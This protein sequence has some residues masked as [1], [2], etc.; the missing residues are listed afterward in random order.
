MTSIAVLGPGGVGGFIAGALTRAGEEVTVLARESSAQVLARDGL[1]I[2]SVILGEFDARP[3]AV[4]QL[5]EPVD[6]LIIATKAVDLDA[7]LQRVQ[8]TPGLVVP[9][10]NGLDHMQLLRRR[11][12]AERVAAGTIRIEADRPEPGR[13]VH[14][15]R[16]LQVDLASEHAEAAPALERLAGRLNRA[17]VPARIGPSEAQILWSKLV[18]LNALALTTSASAERLG[19]IRSD[20]VWREALLG[21]LREGAAVARADGAELDPAKPLGE[22]EAAHAELNSSMQRDVAAGREP[23]LD[24]IAGSVLRAARRHGLACPTIERLSGEVARRA[25]IEPPRV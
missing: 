19:F 13:I 21:C 1:H 18:R 25:G 20:P 9:L 24:A 16:F 6:V 2:Q 7:A 5:A 15:S 23:E 22:L 11:F 17:E 12:P 14:T 3:A 10:L 8:A 4:T